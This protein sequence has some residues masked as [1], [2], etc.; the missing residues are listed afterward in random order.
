MR[1]FT[2][3]FAILILFFVYGCSDDSSGPGEMDDLGEAT[4]SVSGDIDINHTGQADFWSMQFSGLNTWEIHMNDFN[5]QTFSLT[6]LLT[7]L[8][9]IER[10]GTGTYELNEADGF[11]VIYE[12][13]ENQDFQNARE[14]SNTFCDNS[15]NGTLTISS[16]SDSEIRGS[17]NTTISEYDIDDAGQCVNL[18]TVTVSGNFRATPRMG[19]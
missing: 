4:L 18:G 5:P 13:I 15:D 2:M 9:A 3:I 6:F 17:F 8:D 1:Y 14:F 11:S 10:P 7:S 16:S 19:L 12:F